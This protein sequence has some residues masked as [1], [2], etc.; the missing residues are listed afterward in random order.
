VGN[1]AFGGW[2]R[3]DVDEMWRLRKRVESLRHF[4]LLFR[5]GINPGFDA[6]ADAYRRS[7]VEIYQGIARAARSRVI[8]DNSKNPN[9]AALLRS[10]PEIDLRVI[11]LVRSSYGVC[12]S[13]TKSIERTDAPGRTMLQNSA[14]R[15]ALQ[16][17]AFN[18]GFEVLARRG[19]PRLVVRY[20]DFVADPRAEL[21]RMLDFL[22]Y[23]YQSDDLAFVGNGTIDLLPDHSIWGNPSRMQ[24]GPTAV[25]PD[26]AWRDALPANRRCLVG[27]ITAP[28][29]PRYGYPIR[30]QA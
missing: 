22:D 4:P 12:Y 17:L 15:S 21:V 2:D 30:G 8:V 14:G 6:D 5:R 13:W 29:L 10:A 25:A 1:L 24:S 18:G 9:R 27:T 28:L 19:V 26:D 7:A 11:H 23:P 3:V 20:E 16:W